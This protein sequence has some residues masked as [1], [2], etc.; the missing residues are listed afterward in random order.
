MVSFRRLPL[1]LAVPF[2]L[3]A[4]PPLEPKA[5]A[6]TA[7]V[8]LEQARKL[9]ADPPA[10]YR[11]MPLWVWNDE[12][13][14]ARIR[15]MLVQYRQ[16]GLGGAFVHPRPGLM[17]E[18]LSPEWFR[19]WREAL[20]EGKR[21][22]LFINIYDENSYPSGFAG[23]HVPA[24]APETASQF[25]TVETGLAA[26]AVS[27]H[28]QHLAFFAGPR[29][30]SGKLRRVRT[31][32]EVKEGEEVVAFRLRRASGNA[33][34]ANFPYVDLTHPRTAEVFLETTYEAY[35]REFG[36][37]FGRVIRWAFTDEPLIATG[38]AYDV[39]LPALPLSHDTL[40]AFRQ[41]NG[42]DLTDHLPSLFWDTGDWRRVRFDYWQT[43]H[44]VWIERFMRPMFEWCDRHG[45]QF[46]GHFME[47][48]WP[49]P[50][51]SPADA[52]LHAFQHVPG[53]DM[54]G[55]QE[56]RP[57]Y[58][59]TI[60]QSA[61]VSHQLGRRLFCEAYGVSG[62]DATLEHLKR[63]GD[64]LLANGVN[65]VDQHLSFA[66]IRGARKRDHPQ[67][68]SDVASWWRAYRPHADHLARVS[69]LSS[70]S[71]A[72]N[73]VLVI[74]PT[75]SG[76]LFARRAGQTPEL[77][78]M[79]ENNARLAQFLVERHVDFDYGDEYVLEWFG[80]VEGG[81]LRV[82]RATYDVVVLSHDVVNLRHQ[83]VS[84]LEAWL[85]GGGA[86]VSL[87]DPPEFVDGRS[88]E[89]LK[90]LR[91]KAG[92]QWTRVFD[93]DSLLTVLRERV[94][95]RVE[96]EA[97]VSVLERFFASGDRVLFFANHGTAPVSAKVRVRGAAALEEWDTLTGR[98]HAMPASKNQTG[99]EFML[100]LAPAGSLLAVARTQPGPAAA[101]RTF[102]WRT[103]AAPSWSATLD[104]PNVLVLD[105]CDLESSGQK[106]T[107]V[108]TWMANW[109]VWQWHG[110]ERPAWDNAVQ[111]RRNVLD[112][113][114]GEGSGFR[115]TFRFDVQGA[116][117]KG[118]RLA[119]ESPELYQVTVNGN[120]VDFS[121]AE[122]WMDPHI[123][124][125]PIDTF[126]KSGTNEVVIAGAPFDPRMELENIYILGSFALTS[127]EKGFQ[128]GPA[129]AL[130]FGSW[131]QQGRPFYSWSVTYSAKIRVPAGHS[132]LRVS[133]REWS[134]AAAE[135]LVNGQ[136][137]GWIGWPPYETDVPVKPG[138]TTV[139][140]RVHGTPRNLFGPF[141]HPQKIRFRAWP[142]AWAE[143]PEHQPAGKDYDLLDY[144]L[145]AAPVLA[146][147]P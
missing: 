144:G 120:R 87:A 29:G 119:V 26:A 115:A 70:V 91:E 38:G 117:P 48:D 138:A 27:A 126:V 47:Q 8:P 10:E 71:E 31:P 45:I 66:T 103:L 60:R 65:F 49:Y 112:R 34:T 5:P 75:T 136:A 11:P 83:T 64:W 67:S 85:G 52:S 23:G 128:I 39:S 37:E 36:A 98:I 40:A 68:F 106:L 18:Y 9:F 50:W 63:F 143:F 110:F 51:R 76:F 142:N 86:V 92:K 96:T 72:R 108:N 139:E 137:P 79:R 12:M 95:P 20:E 123:Q 99:L 4:Q 141:H 127:A 41:R 93:E 105:Y 15:E 134:G 22:G 59:F 14:A 56:L 107:D 89:A 42:Y 121:A 2:L 114:F 101:A 80:R 78:K 129:K 82:G 130:T 124:A 116:P 132:R 57:H 43:L 58:L 77:E 69:L 88:S 3:A 24:R 25:V 113:K 44:D 73:R 54:L 147:A 90:R 16:Q 30:D 118:M 35:R 32:K 140:V 28:P 109:R 102:G 46:T 61:S 17:T 53:I 21:L 125:A 100:N 55:G 1:L 104:G 122:R 131:R 133:L 111:F 94:P 62:W 135:I 97:P 13:E 146:T 81:K 6:A 7:P 33:W 19:L 74:H 84:L 145:M